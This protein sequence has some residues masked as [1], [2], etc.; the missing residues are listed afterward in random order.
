ME[1]KS[2]AAIIQYLPFSG[3]PKKVKGT[4][5]TPMIGKVNKFCILLVTWWG[6]ENLFMNPK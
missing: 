5:R 1:M 4:V 3:Y 6:K 2:I